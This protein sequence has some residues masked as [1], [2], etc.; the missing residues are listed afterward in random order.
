M[1]PKIPVEEDIYCLIPIT[2]IGSELCIPLIGV[3]GQ[4]YYFYYCSLTIFTTIVFCYSIHS[5]NFLIIYIN[6]TKKNLG[7]HKNSQ[8][9]KINIFYMKKLINHYIYERT[10][11][12]SSFSISHIWSSICL[13]T[14]YP[15]SWKKSLSFNSHWTFIFVLNWLRSV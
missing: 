9:H 2:E 3:I 12:V 10:L 5:H 4:W 14:L 11:L 1:S 7:I 15:A 13:V 6:I 8:T